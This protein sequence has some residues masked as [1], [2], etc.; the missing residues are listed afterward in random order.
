LPDDQE[1]SRVLWYVLGGARGG[2]TRAK[3][4][5]QLAE[6][7]CNM[8]QLSNKLGVDY[9]TITHHIGILLKNSL[10]VSEGEGYGVAYFLSPRL[11]SNVQDFHR[12]CAELGFGSSSG[13]KPSWGS[14]HLWP[15]GQSRSRVSYTRFPFL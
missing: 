5:V 13:G 2:E 1:L 3:I 11:Q 6:R 8:N 4:L 9:R 10:V 12:I 14:F 7:P 15:S